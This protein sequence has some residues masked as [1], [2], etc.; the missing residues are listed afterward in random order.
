MTGSALAGKLTLLPGLGLPAIVSSRVPLANRLLRGRPARHAP[1]LLGS[2]YALCGQAHR[3]TAQLAIDAAAGV[4]SAATPQEHAA[5]AA[6]T[7]REHV[8]RIWLDWPRLLGA[9]DAGAGYAAVLR[10]CPLF[11]DGAADASLCDWIEQALTGEP[12]ADWLADWRADPAACMARWTRRGQTMPARL[13]HGIADV[14]AELDRLERL[15]RDAPAALALRPHAEQGALLELAGA[16]EADHGFENQP[17]WRGR[18]A[19]TGSWNRL[20]DAGG[21]TAPGSWLRLGARVAELAALASAS[22]ADAPLLSAGALALGPGEA[23]AWSEMARGLLLHRVRLE[24]GQSSGQAEAK[25]AD[26]K[27]VAPT[28][29]NFHPRGVVASIL[30]QLPAAAENV[31]PIAAGKA[32]QRRLI[33]VLAA[34]FDPCVSYEI[35]FE[36]A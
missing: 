16:L 36:H 4:R 35:E 13:L 11:Q 33:G 24:S 31:A 27:I 2:L 1:A 3:L 12:P 10:A 8:R 32:A 17:L 26:Y 29:W 14:A 7:M 15:E 22:A 30:A 20:A 21:L 23:L 5:L 18:C 25:V 6:E 28:E 19:E 9:D 34:A